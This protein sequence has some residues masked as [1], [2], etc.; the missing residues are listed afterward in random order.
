VSFC[1]AIGENCNILFPQAAENGGNAGALKEADCEANRLREI[2]E[3]N[4]LDSTAR[5]RAGYAEIALAL[6]DPLDIFLVRN[7]SVPRQEKLVTGTI[8]IGGTRVDAEFSSV[9][10]KIYALP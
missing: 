7:S 2:A 1:A 4:G 10:A 9:T 5:P 8:I 6:N 3:D